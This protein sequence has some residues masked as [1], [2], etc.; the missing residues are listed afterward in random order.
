M[1]TREKNKSLKDKIILIDTKDQYKLGPLY[2]FI[3]ITKSK[4]FFREDNLYI[5]IPGDTIF[6]FNILKEIMKNV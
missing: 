2:S 6:E 4:S 1:S 3:S 5:L